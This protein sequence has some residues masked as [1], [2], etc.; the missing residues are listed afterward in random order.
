MPSVGGAANRIS[1]AAPWMIGPTVMRAQCSVK[2]SRSRRSI[3]SPSTETSSYSVV[4]PSISSSMVPMAGIVQGP[5]SLQL[6]D[7]RQANPEGAG[8]HASGERLGAQLLHGLHRRLVEQP[9]GGR[10]DDGYVADHPARQNRELDGDGA[11]QPAPTGHGWIAERR[12]D[13]LPQPGQIFGVD[14]SR[15]SAL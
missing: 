12:V 2:S 5:G 15:V 7:D 11:R 6:E 4:V 9:M 1:Q 3:L 10:L 13:T 8:R 14:G